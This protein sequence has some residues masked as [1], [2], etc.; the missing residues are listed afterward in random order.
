VSRNRSRSNPPKSSN[1]DSPSQMR[2]QKFLSQC[3]VASRR[4]AEEMIREG[5]IQVNDVTITELG[6]KINPDKDIVRV[7]RR[8]V[9]PP[10][11]G[12]LLLHKPKGVVST[13]SDPEG[14][15]SIADY[16]TKHFKSYYPV[17]RLDFD[18]TG[19][20]IL[21]NDGELAEHLMHPRYGFERVYHVRVEGSISE[22]LIEKIE[23]GVRLEDGLIKGKAKL[24]KGD[25]GSTWL[26][27]IVKEGRNRVIRRLMD[28]LRHP[29]MKLRRV[30]YGPFKLGTL[31]TGEMRKLED[32][33]YRMIRE[34]IL[35]KKVEA[36]D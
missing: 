26:E 17:G 9:K 25:D 20:I 8:I 28:R 13:L 34:R 31:K 2:L 27:I 22:R 29:V 30:S 3:G 15:P 1:D 5:V 18:S 16:L 10:E 23:T 4:H 19:L 12:I 35:R 7:K 14:R 21:T 11:R 36:N 33:E 6:F 24:L 32:R